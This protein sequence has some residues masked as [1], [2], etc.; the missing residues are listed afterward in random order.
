MATAIEQRKV[1][2]VVTE[3]GRLLADKGFNR[4]EMLIGLSELIGRIIVDVADTSIQ[5]E[6]L[7][8]IC[9]QHMLKTIEIGSRATQKSIIERA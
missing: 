3:A 1:I 5:A 4:G 9:Q 6:E 7:Y 8:G 2:G